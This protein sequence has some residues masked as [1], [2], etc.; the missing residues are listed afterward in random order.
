M[1]GTG[2]YKWNDERTYNGEWKDGKMHGK[3]TSFWKE[4][5]KYVGEY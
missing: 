5:K 1:N 2:T 4:G 3:G